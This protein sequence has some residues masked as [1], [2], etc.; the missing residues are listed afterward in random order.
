MKIRF[1]A[2]LFLATA[3][4]LASAQS[5][6][7]ILNESGSKYTSQTWFYSGDG[8][9][10]QQDKI[11]DNWDSGKKITSMAYTSKG[12]FFVMSKNSGITRQR[13]KISMKW[14][15][16]W[17]RSN[18]DEDFYISQI[19]CGDSEW[20]VVMSQGE[21]Y[22]NQS[23]KRDRWSIMTRWISE[24]WEQGKYITS[25]AFDGEKWV[26]VM[27]KHHKYSFQGYFWARDYK[28]LVD[29]VKH[30]V[31]DR[32]FSV[33]AIEY[34]DGAYLVVYGTSTNSTARRQDF[35]VDPAN[36]RN[37]ISRAWDDDFK[38]VYLGGSAPFSDFGVEG[39]SL[40]SS[41]DVSCQPPVL[42]PPPPPKEPQHNP[43]G[44]QP[45]H[46]Q[47]EHHQAAPSTPSQPRMSSRSRQPSSQSSRVSPSK[48]K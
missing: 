41:P 48:R 46:H 26:A 30:Q 10:V 47:P 39:L 8:K 44:H 3:C 19:S 25:V 22:T 11:R 42:L 7:I 33:H 5:R 21:G 37:Y 45:E 6:T 28:D 35:A 34:G 4:T 23:W 12:W 31:W 17:I 16:D 24:K 38:I 27:S 14:P 2:A 18:W 1:F 36:V 13:Y 43:G 29:K 32:Q 40:P 15:S 20:M 9:P